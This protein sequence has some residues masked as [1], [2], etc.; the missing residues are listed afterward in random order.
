MSA[1]RPIRSDDDHAD[2]L[3]RVEALWNADPG[4]PEGDELEVLVDLIEHYEERRFALP[5]SDPPDILIAHMEAT[6]RTRA[7]LIELLG[8]APRASEVLRR[9]RPLTV[10]M[11]HR[12]HT[13]WGVPAGLLTAPYETGAA[14]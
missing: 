3:A 13:E 2:A 9:R 10:E 8:S 12:L 5:P 11:I 7:D 6:G 14:A 1:I 4:T